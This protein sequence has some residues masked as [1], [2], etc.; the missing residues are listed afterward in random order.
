M[1]ILLKLL[2]TLAILFVAAGL[3]LFVD[4]WGWAVLIVIILVWVV[5]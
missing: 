5:G 1:T 2:A 4:V 3:G